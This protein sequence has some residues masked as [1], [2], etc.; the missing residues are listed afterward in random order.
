MA[1]FAREGQFDSIWS[2]NWDCLLENALERVGL[3]RDKPR[4]D[5]PWKTGYTT[6]ITVKDYTGAGDLWA[7]TVFKPH[8]CVR[9]L[10]EA[11]AALAGLYKVQ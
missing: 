1:R 9:S 11:R 4:P 10:D 3:D 2:L 5:L 6:F 8:G 7:V